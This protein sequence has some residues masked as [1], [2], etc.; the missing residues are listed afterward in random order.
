MDKPLCI[1]HGNC[2]DGF[3]AAWV[4][5]KYYKGEVDFHK[6]IYGDRAPDVSGRDVIIVDFSYK[7][8][9][10]EWIISKSKSLLVLDHHK[11]AEEDLKGL[12]GATEN[13]KVIFDMDRSGSGLTWDH[14]FPQRKR[15]LFLNYVEDRDL[16]R[17]KLSSY[18]V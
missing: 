13:V 7:R 6:G 5:H 18:V 1:Y 14:F 8:P 17:F 9:V 12:D 16:W 11:S 10:M 3:T 2:L 15:P 4:A